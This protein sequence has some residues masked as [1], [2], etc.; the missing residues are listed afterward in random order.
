MKAP[1]RGWQCHVAPDGSGAPLAWRMNVLP[2]LSRMFDT[3]PSVQSGSAKMQD[4]QVIGPLVTE[5]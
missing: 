5:A 2:R 4:T 3:R 1:L